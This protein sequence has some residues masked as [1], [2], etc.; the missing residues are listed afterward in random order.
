MTGTRT[1][2]GEARRA[3]LVDAAAGLVVEEGVAAVTHRAVAARS[4]LPL[5]ATTYY[6]ADRSDL[7]LAAVEQAART[8]LARARAVAA[9]AT[10]AAAGDGTAATEAAADPSARTGLAG[11]LL[12]LVV[13]AERLGEV[14]RLAAAYERFL[15][16]VRTP[17]LAPAL[18]GWQEEVLQLI[19]QVLGCHGV[20]LAPRTALALVDG[21]AV[22]AMTEGVVSRE[23]LVEALALALTDCCR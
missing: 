22:Q 16:L 17:A 5:A 11:Q 1:P 13:G 14:P 12:D 7:V 21:C 9:Q 2:K 3:A 10:A 23:A 4:R 20:D 15:E 18:A 6:F 8:E 19:D